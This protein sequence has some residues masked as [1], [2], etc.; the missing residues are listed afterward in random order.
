MGHNRKFNPPDGYLTGEPT[1]WQ[2]RYRCT[3]PKHPAWK[4]YGG[5]G[6]TVC[7]RWLN[8]F[9][10]FYADMGHAREAVASTVST[11]TAITSPATADGLPQSNR[12]TIN[13]SR[14]ESRATPAT[15]ERGWCANV[16]AAA[17]AG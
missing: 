11:T 12:Q 6:I 15:V 9:E 13:E 2:M 17:R 16:L 3:N 4:D 8:S 5:R 7:D 1:W 10:N 14:S